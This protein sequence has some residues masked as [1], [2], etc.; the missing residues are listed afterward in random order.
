MKYSSHPYARWFLSIISFLE[1]SFFPFPPDPLY[2]AMALKDRSK[3][4][5]LS[6]LCTFSSVV[7]G[8][9]GYLIGYSFYE[10]WGEDI[11][12]FYGL[13]ESFDNLRQDFSKWGFWIIV[14]KGFTPIP[15]KLVTIV[16][17][18]ANFNLVYF[19]IASIF[20]R[21]FRFFYLGVLIWRF[22]SQIKKYIENNLAL[23]VIL[24]MLF[25]IGGFLLVKYFW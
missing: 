18:A 24:T 13:T 1:S 20:A 11:I 15:Y 17:G 4:W 10:Y 25:L 16:S 12:V 21:G 7:G 8:Y 23:S 5:S 6:I 19:T 14:L 22:G 3:I 9:L 2:I